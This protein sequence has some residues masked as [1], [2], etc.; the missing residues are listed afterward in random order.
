M[1]GVDSKWRNRAEF[2][3]SREQ[4]VAFLQRKWAREL[5]WPHAPALRPHQRS[6]NQRGQAEI[7]LAARPSPRRSPWARR[8][9]FVDDR[10]SPTCLCTCHLESLDSPAH[11]P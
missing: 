4:I 10:V 6:A 5:D 9:R 8:A 1:V 7:S 3:G 2:L 11:P